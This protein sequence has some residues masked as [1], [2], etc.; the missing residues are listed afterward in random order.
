MVG[1]GIAGLA[2]AWEL[3]SR[4]SD[5]SVTVFDPGPPGG[6]IRTTQFEGRAVDEGPD[7]FLTRVP[8]AVQLC[9]ELG[10]TGELVGPAAGSSMVWWGGR[11]RPL[12]DGLVL[13]VPGRL[14]AIAR[15][16]ILS[17]FG[18]LRAGLDLL[19]PRTEIPDDLSVY[20]LVAAR[21]GKEVATR[22]VDPLVGGIHAGR[23]D[24]L[25]ASATV[26]QL[27]SA[28]RRS[29]SLLLAL[30]T[31]GSAGPT[32]PVFLTPRL[33][34]GRMV[35]VLVSKL[36]E[37]GATFANRAVGPLAPTAGGGISVDGGDRYD[38]VV[39][40]APAPAAAGLV[41]AVSPS[42]ATGL[43]EIDHASVVVVTMSFPAGSVPVPEGV[44]GFLVPRTAGRLMT[45]CS[46]ASAKWPHWGTAGRT[47]VRLS[48]GRSGDERAIGLGDDTLVERLSEE[49]GIALSQ[50]LPAPDS[51]RV[52]RW[53][54]S[55]PQYSVGHSRRVASIDA[56]LASDQPGIALAGAAY[57][58]AGIPAC[59]GSGRR[60]AG[61]L[62]A[63]TSPGRDRGLGVG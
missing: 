33:G 24:E 22:L 45:A 44:N 10:I 5:A 57:R 38:G 60:A 51:A 18:A 2:A 48:A 61:I 54:G 63:M 59:I 39:L 43:R 11:L 7:A 50:R 62:L 32:G 12:P 15:S 29:R 35:E 21:F 36:K 49:L 4:S 56:A 53:A 26:P 41:D 13:G 52:T 3:T 27:V 20:D 6:K 40:A 31:M 30:R 9:A 8:E 25:S 34:L 37:R 42:A 23:T 47:L 58:G 28:A 1:S 19:L 16:G 46:F 14:S 55:F 17:P